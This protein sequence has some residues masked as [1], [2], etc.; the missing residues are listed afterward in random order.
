[1]IIKN[2]KRKTVLSSNCKFASSF[3]DKTLGLLRKSIPRAL[4]FKTRFG[5]H[6]FFLTKPIDVLVL[7][8]KYIV[9]S[10]KEGLQPNKV[11]F[12]NPKYFWVLELPAGTIKKS[13]TQTK[14]RLEILG[15]NK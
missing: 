3:L 14:Y 4:L 7:D 13:K 12:W 10:I 11:F 6:T 15:M 5:L 2:P 1:M 8:E 9:Q